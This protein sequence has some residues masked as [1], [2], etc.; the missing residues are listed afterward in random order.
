MACARGH[1]AKRL[2]LSSQAAAMMAHARLKTLRLGD[3]PSQVRGQFL[4]G[5]TL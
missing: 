2:V 4:D 3:N 5:S 1:L